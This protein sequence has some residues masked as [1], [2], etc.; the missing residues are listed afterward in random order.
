MVTGNNGGGSVDYEPNSF[1][2]PV[3]DKTIM[4]PPLKIDGNGARDTTYPGDDMDLDGQRRAF[5]EK[6]LDDTGK[7]HLVANIVGSIMAD[8]AKRQEIQQ[9]M[10]KHW[11]LRASGR[12]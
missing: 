6:V 4:E 1:A 3:E 8:D 10:L 2:G 7:A 11:Y 12:P 9:R 5:W